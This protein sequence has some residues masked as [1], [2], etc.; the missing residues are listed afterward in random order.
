MAMTAEQRAERARKAGIASGRAR[1]ETSRRID[2][3][4]HVRAVVDNAPQLTLE[5]AARLRALFAGTVA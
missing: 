1:R 4:A 5:Q 3:E 2:L